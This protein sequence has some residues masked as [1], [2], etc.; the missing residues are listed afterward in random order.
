MDIRTFRNIQHQD[1]FAVHDLTHRFH[2]KRRLEGVCI[3]SCHLQ[4]LDDIRDCP[5]FKSIYFTAFIYSQQKCSSSGIQKCTDCLKHICMDSIL[6]ASEHGIFIF[7]NCDQFLCCHIFLLHDALAASIM[8]DLEVN[9]QTF[10]PEISGGSQIR[11][12]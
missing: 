9:F 8:V 11:L 3:L 1:I 5:F 2:L 12:L 10:P 7:S 4:C 6:A